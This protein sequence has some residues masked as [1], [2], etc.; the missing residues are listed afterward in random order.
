M[1]AVERK[2]LVNEGNSPV[3]ASPFQKQLKSAHRIKKTPNVHPLQKVVESPHI[4]CSDS[5]QTS[6]PPNSE[7]EQ[8]APKGA[9]NDIERR[10]TN[11]GE[12]LTANGPS[13]KEHEH[14]I[15]SN[16]RLLR[17]DSLSDTNREF[18]QEITKLTTSRHEDIREIQGI[19]SQNQNTLPYLPHSKDKP[20]SAV[21][22]RSA[23]DNCPLS[24]TSNPVRIA[25][26]K[27]KTDS[28][29]PESMPRI[30]PPQDVV[31][32]QTYKPMLPASSKYYE[33]LQKPLLENKVQSPSED[34]RPQREENR[35]FEENQENTSRGWMCCW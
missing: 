6:E 7:F 18:Q 4:D 30:V 27:E 3:Q 20:S 11:S 31:V 15:D 32:D 1:P 2:E 12:Y 16:E 17:Y 29:V 23:Y 10:A 28:K 35:I 25:I 24:A 5:S 21:A 33:D 13:S 8:V 26:L 22:P 34:K 9:Q 14:R 19:V